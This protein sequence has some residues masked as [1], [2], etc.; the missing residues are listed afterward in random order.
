MVSNSEQLKSC[1]PAMNRTMATASEVN[2]LDAD[3]A[4]PLGQDDVVWLDIPV[5]PVL[6]QI[7]QDLDSIRPTQF[8][9]WATTL[10]PSS[11]AS[12]ANEP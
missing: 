1:C 5:A 6:M 2:E 7:V 11:A 3:F 12:L 4:F 8:A 9:L 10:P